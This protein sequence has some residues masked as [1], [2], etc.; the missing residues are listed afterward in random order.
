MTATLEAPVTPARAQLPGARMLRRTLWLIVVTALS[1]F[2]YG[3]LLVASKGG[4]VGPTVWVDANGNHVDADGRPTD[5]TQTT[6]NVVL[7]ANPAMY[8]P[9]ALIALGAIMLVLR[10]AHDEETAIRILSWAMWIIPAVA[11]A[12]IVIGY[13]WFFHTPLDYWVQP[14]WRFATFPFGSVDVTTQPGTP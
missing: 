7:H 1:A 11:V 5:A 8:V 12:A 10:R 2:T 14:G 13:V 6:V 9:L 3:S 4:G